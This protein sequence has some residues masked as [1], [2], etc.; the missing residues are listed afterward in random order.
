VKQHAINLLPAAVQA[1]AAKGAATGRFISS[2]VV[3]AIAVG[4]ACT[5]AKLRQNEA[6]SRYERARD[7][8]DLVI[9]TEQKQKELERTLKEIETRVERYALVAHPVEVSRIAATIVNLMPPSAVLDRLDIEAGARRPLQSARSP[10]SDGKQKQPRPPRMMTGELAGFAASELD[11]AELVARLSD[12]PP[13]HEVRLE[14]SRHRMVRERNARE[15]RVSFKV[16]L[17]ADY[18]IAVAEPEEADHAN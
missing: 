14:F 16:D 9:Q 10:Q 5:W 8:A 4:V 17:E 15:F 2:I 18:T 13:F 12:R 7:Q 1:R 3:A 11:V 6:R